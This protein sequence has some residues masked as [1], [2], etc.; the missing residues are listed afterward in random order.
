MGK[1]ASISI[2]L[3]GFPERKI[4]S[5]DPRLGISCSDKCLSFNGGGALLLEVLYYYDFFGTVDEFFQIMR[6]SGSGSMRA[7]GN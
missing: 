3:K 5:A 1:P 2:G 6:K 4:A 7:V